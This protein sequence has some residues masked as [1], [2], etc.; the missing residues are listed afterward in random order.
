MCPLRDAAG[1]GEDRAIVAL[2]ERHRDVERDRRPQPP[3]AARVVPGAGSAARRSPRR[4]PRAGSRRARGPRG[5]PTRSRPSTTTLADGDEAE[6]DE[7]LAREARVDAVGEHERQHRRHHQ[8]HRQA[9][10]HERRV[11]RLEVVPRR[12]ERGRRPSRRP[13]RATRSARRRCREAADPASCPTA[14]RRGSRGWSARRRRAGSRR[15]SACRRGRGTTPTAAADRIDEPHERGE[16]DARAPRAPTPACA[17]A[18]ARSRSVT[19]LQPGLTSIASRSTVS[20]W[21]AARLSVAHDR[22]RDRH[23]RRA[24]AP[25]HAPRMRDLHDGLVGERGDLV[26]GPEPRARGGPARRDVL[27]DDAAVLVVQV[28]AEPRPRRGVAPALRSRSA[29]TGSTRSTGTNMLP[30]VVSPAIT[31]CTNSEPMPTSRPS[32]SMQAAPPQLG[33]G[34][35]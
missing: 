18:T 28:D 2:G 21:H 13:G 30:R 10:P 3:C 9:V 11:R 14:R 26:A 25:Q 34:G 8:R 35:A 33:C 15:A 31:C 12:A 5:R 24:L 19:S 6:R 7:R 22:Q 32:R 20:T 1:R 29:R 17:R 27:H 4:Y 16:R 23:A